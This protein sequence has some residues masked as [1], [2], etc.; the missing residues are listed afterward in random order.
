MVPSKVMGG[1]TL[2]IGLGLVAILPGCTSEL[3]D[4]LK[5]TDDMSATNDTGVE[6]D[7]AN[8]EDDEQGTESDSPA[9]DTATLD[10][11]PSPSSSEPPTDT[12]NA[13]G[14]AG[15]DESD[16]DDTTSTGEP[17][18]PDP[19][20]APTSDSDASS[21]A[22]PDDTGPEPEEAGATE[23]TGDPTTE[24]TSE[25][26]DPTTTSDEDS[27]TSDPGTDPGTSDPATDETTVEQDSGTPEPPAEPLEVVQLAPAQDAMDADTAANLVV[28]FGAPISLGT[29]TIEIVDLD[30]DAPVES[31]PVGDA[32]VSLTEDSISVDLDSLLMGGTA[33]SVTVP[34]GAFAGSGGEVFE[35]ASWSFQTASISVPGDVSASDLLAWFDA[36]YAASVKAAS[37]VIRLWADR[38]GHRT[39]V[40]QATSGKRP[41]LVPNSLGGNPVVRFD[42]VDDFLL[43]PDLDDP[44]AYDLFVVWRSPDAPT[45]EDL[46]LLVTNGVLDTCNLQLTY[47]HSFAGYEH[48]A[49]A[50]FGETFV[51]AAFAAPVVDTATLWNSSFAAGGPL[52][53]YTNGA[54]TTS[55]AT[56][57][58]LVSATERFT[59]A[60][61]D[62]GVYPFGGDIAEL[63]LF[64]RALNAGER[65]LVEEYLG[66]KWGLTI[67]D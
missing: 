37:N 44:S 34:A 59:L 39:N 15:Q 32:R 21:P 9:D 43:G 53:A 16:S 29:G 36:D 6:V 17:P 3:S 12:S 38:S 41:T 35:G 60:G 5:V 22:N 24:P 55:T 49:V 46:T 1:W 61:T 25:P 51:S 28:T 52:V 2:L 58:D 20:S 64:S 48:S 63:L 45:T 13:G 27:G 40:L 10:D 42:G 8:T 62:Q 14:D 30:A 31:I 50:E 56:S 67:A 54:Q 11:T 26:T 18:S 57:G 47:G 7:D 23:P 19:T 66:A 33:Y 65:E 4:S